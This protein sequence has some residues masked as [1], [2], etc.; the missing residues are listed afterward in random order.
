[1]GGGGGVG[2]GVLNKVLYG[3]ASQIIIKP[4]RFVDF[5]TSVK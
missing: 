3:E 1:M 5:F 4:E 2:V